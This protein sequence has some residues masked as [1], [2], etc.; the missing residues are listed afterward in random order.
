MH[1]GQFHYAGRLGIRG[2]VRLGHSE[3]GRSLVF[4]QGKREEDDN[5][6]KAIFSRIDFVT[7][8]GR[9]MK[10]LE[11]FRA[12]QCVTCRCLATHPGKGKSRLDQFSKLDPSTL[13]IYAVRQSLESRPKYFDQSGNDASSSSQ[14]IRLEMQRWMRREISRC[15]LVS[16]YFI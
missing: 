7:G 9:W 4:Q 11:T 1:A 16:W 14:S 2:R 3:A 13:E 12:Q 10:C 8:G 15:K 6:Y 5:E